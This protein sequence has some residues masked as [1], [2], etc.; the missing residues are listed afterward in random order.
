MSHVILDLKL[1]R[2]HYKFENTLVFN[3]RLWK[4]N[5][6][7]PVLGKIWPVI[8]R[9]TQVAKREI[10]YIL[11]FG[12]ACWLWG[13]LFINRQNQSSARNAINKET[14]AINEKKVKNWSE[15][16]F[17]VNWKFF[18][19]PFAVENY[20]LPRGQAQPIRFHDDTRKPSRALIT[21]WFHRDAAS[22]QKRVVP[23]GCAG[24]MP[25]SASGRLSI[26]VSRLKTETIRTWPF[27]HQDSSGSE[28]RGNDQ[29]QRKRT[30]W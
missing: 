18:C 26:Y 29:R 28:N 8:G 17:R 10:F 13:T 23:C 16:C 2:S 11:P 4:I 27:D 24:T 20:F 25:H 22:F 19:F 5:L 14:K 1:H 7:P 15:N 21:D 3:F 12:I 30:G 9:A 6:S